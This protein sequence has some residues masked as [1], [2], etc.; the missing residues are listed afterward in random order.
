M[1][2]PKKQKDNPEPK[3]ESELRLA[4][5]GLNTCE[6][7]AKDLMF[8]LEGIPK[9][10]NS[11]TLE[12]CKAYTILLFETYIE[13]DNDRELMLA[14]CGLLE[15]YEFRP[16]K[17][18]ARMWEY[19]QHAKKYNDF[20]NGKMSP[21]SISGMCRKQLLRIA[22]E[23]EENLKVQLEKNEGK[24]GL[25]ANVPET[26]KLPIPRDV[27]SDSCDVKKVSTLEEIIIDTSDDSKIVITKI[28]S[29]M[30]KKIITVSKESTTEIKF[31]ASLLLLIIASS[32]GVIPYITDN[33][34]HTNQNDGKFTS[35]ALKKDISKE[36]QEKQNWIL[37][38]IPYDGETN[39]QPVKEYAETTA[40][41]KSSLRQALLLNIDPYLEDADHRSEVDIASFF[42]GGG[43]DK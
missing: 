20:L 18:G 30:A 11:K 43:E 37:K 26:L 41:A 25:I 19:R 17:Y 4:L 27:P 2:R 21:V 14:I 7:N 24:L 9:E 3:K 1:A 38:A 31:I 5:I 15:G 23:L 42:L 40:A 29:N 39:Q 6:T 13:D 10:P 35:D 28:L 34:I 8:L 36:G 33:K 22:G 12:F 32:I 16:R